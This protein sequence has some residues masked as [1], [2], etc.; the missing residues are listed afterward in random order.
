[1]RPTAA[2]KAE[3]WARLD[4]P[5]LPLALLRAIAGSFGRPGQEELLAPYVE[6]YLSSLRRLWEERTRE[7]ALSLARGLFPHTLVDEGVVAAVDR[8]LADEALPRPLRRI[9]AEGADALRRA[10]RARAAD[11]PAAS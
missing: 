1:S 10:R 9:L 2:A 3:A 7:E 6:R 8:A 5:G 4:E 11:R